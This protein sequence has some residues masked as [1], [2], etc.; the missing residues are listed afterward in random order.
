MTPASAAAQTSQT[1][2][3]APAII[4][5]YVTFTVANQLFGIPVM[6]VQD[7]L[8][9]GRI[10]PVPLAPPEV[11][12]AINLRGRIVTVIDMHR[13]LGLPREGSAP[14]EAMGVTVESGRD[15]Y[16]LLVD[17]VGD[18][19]SLAAHLREPNPSTLDRLW[20]EF[21]DGVFTLRD[22]LMVVLDA[23]RLLHIRRRA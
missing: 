17:S 23:E 9:P 18:V 14:A 10:A 3:A 8:V 20:L 4:T 5:D 16:T 1:R 19:I 13:R 7:I 15:L 6:Q 2:P 22:R 21:A 11:R 12:G